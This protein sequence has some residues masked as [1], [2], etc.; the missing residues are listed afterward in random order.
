MAKK[1]G[2]GCFIT[3][4]L[5]RQPLRMARHGNI[6]KNYRPQSAKAK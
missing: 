5:E 6:E 2:H 4:G 3:I 1:A